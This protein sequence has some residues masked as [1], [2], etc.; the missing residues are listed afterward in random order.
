MFTIQG[1]SL[2][3]LEIHV[4]LL[5]EIKHLSDNYIINVLKEGVDARLT[6]D[7]L[8]LIGFVSVKTNTLVKCSCVTAG[9]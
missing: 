8:S 3:L 6:T 4:K 1:V 2:V 7:A 5:F 9:L